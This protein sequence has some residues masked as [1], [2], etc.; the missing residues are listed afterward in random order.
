MDS[1]TNHDVNINSTDQSVVS[2]LTESTCSASDSHSVASTSVSTT[3]TL[4]KKRKKKGKGGSIYRLYKSGKKSKSNYTPGPSHDRKRQLRERQSDTSI[5]S[6][7]P[8]QLLTSSENSL[9]QRR[10]LIALL[11]KQLGAPPPREWNGPT[12]TVHK[13]V[14]SCHFNFNSRG[15]VR[16]VILRTRLCMQWGIPY[17]GTVV[18][19]RGAPQHT[20][21]DGSYEQKMV[22]NFVERAA[23]SK[24]T[25]AAINIIKLRLN[26]PPLTQSA[27]NECIG[28]MNC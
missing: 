27:V 20:I 13:I 9:T 18:F 21:Q 6:T 4:K 25:Q 22:A 28:R 1:P 3:K 26:L 14:Q 12:G 16:R 24:C 7:E 19:A 8:P 11:Y 15:Q 17:T 10:L 5:E 23:S 2:A